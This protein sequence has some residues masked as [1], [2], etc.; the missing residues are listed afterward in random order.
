MLTSI[1]TNNNKSNYISNNKQQRS[2][3]MCETSDLIEKNKAIKICHVVDV[4]VQTSALNLG[5]IAVE[6][7]SS[8]TH[9]SPRSISAA[10]ASSYSDQELVT[11]TISGS[12][13]SHEQQ[14]LFIKSTTAFGSILA[15]NHSKSIQRSQ[16]AH[17]DS[18]RR[19]TAA[20]LGS[21]AKCTRTH[22]ASYDVLAS[23]SLQQ[24]QQTSPPLSSYYYEHQT[25]QNLNNISAM[26]ENETKAMKIIVPHSNPSSGHGNRHH[27]M[28]ATN[29]SKIINFNFQI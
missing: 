24:Q 27:S 19:Q 12:E 20:A 10:T 25:K 4:S 17:L 21:T 6:C 16:T 8:P 26:T 1:K 22:S 9:T 13:E 18:I 15:A 2:S 23:F 5:E 28:L 3:T 14:Q 7:E 29:S 11:S